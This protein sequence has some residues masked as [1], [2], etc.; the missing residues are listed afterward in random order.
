ME[1]LEV[2]VAEQRAPLA[3]QTA[4]LSA[5]ESAVQSHLGALEGAVLA[6]NGPLKQH[7][8]SIAEQDKALQSLSTM[9]RR[10]LPQ[11]LTLLSRQHASCLHIRNPAYRCP[12]ARVRGCLCFQHGKFPS[13]CTPTDRR[14]AFPRLIC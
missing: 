10:G 7:A 4:A 1:Y 2:A 13:F 3:H 5:L 9:V 11:P 14:E 8:A 12:I 6:H